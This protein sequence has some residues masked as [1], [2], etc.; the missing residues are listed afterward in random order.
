MQWNTYEPQKKHNTIGSCHAHHHVMEMA[1]RRM[2]IKCRHECNKA[3]YLSTPAAKSSKAE[4]TTKPSDVIAIKEG[5]YNTRTQ[6]KTIKQQLLSG[7]G[8]LRLGIGGR[9]RLSGEAGGR[10]GLRDER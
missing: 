1:A 3:A 7:V 5:K 4:Q 9:Y 2:K 6:I 8:E 10:L